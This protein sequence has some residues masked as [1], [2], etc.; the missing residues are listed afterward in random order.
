MLENAPLIWV[1]PLRTFDSASERM[2]RL[3]IAQLQKH[4]D[5]SSIQLQAGKTLGLEELT[6]VFHA[7]LS[8]PNQRKVLD[9]IF[10]SPVSHQSRRQKTRWRL[11]QKA[12]SVFKDEDPGV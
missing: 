3:Y 1:L 7:R 10:R 11:L 2:T 9:K 12:E 6:V 4:P 8:V 5:V